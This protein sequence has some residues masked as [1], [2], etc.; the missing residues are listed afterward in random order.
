MPMGSDQTEFKSTVKQWLRSRG[1]DYGWMAERCGVSEITM[2][3]WMSRK[4]I[5]PL[6][7]QL[8]E[9]AMEQQPQFVSGENASAVV[10]GVEVNAKLSLTVQLVPELYWRLTERA[11]AAGATPETLVAQVIADL[12]QEPSD[13]LKDMKQR[14]VTLPT[15]SQS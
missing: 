13:A 5:P 9:R 2:R 10:A 7:V 6:K 11:L 15:N 3:N 12:L 1:L 8:M 14:A 4:F